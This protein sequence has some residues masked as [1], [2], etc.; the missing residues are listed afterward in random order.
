M[1][2]EKTIEHLGDTD[3]YVKENQK[4]GRTSQ[5]RKLELRV[6]KFVD[7]LVKEG[8]ID[9]YQARNLKS[10]DAIP[11]RIYMTIKTHKED[12]PVRPVVST[13]L[14]CLQP[15]RVSSRYIQNGGSG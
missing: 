15:N 8:T 7:K 9:A 6:N 5:T 1:Y 13:R 4:I 2:H 10:H 3:T 14:T 12:Y 11:P